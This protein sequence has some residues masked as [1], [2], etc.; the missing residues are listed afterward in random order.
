MPERY[1][2]KDG[3]RDTDKL[4]DD[5]EPGPEQGRSGGNL[6]RKIGTRDEEKRATERP[7]GTT[8]VEGKDERENQI[9]DNS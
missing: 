8:R 1:R 3:T 7:A 4:I 2:S 9:K 6:A 5:T